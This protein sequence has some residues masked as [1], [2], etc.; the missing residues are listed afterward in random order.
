[1]RKSVLLVAV[2]FV[3][4]LVLANA[5]SLHADNRAA[6]ALA[7]RPITATG[8]AEIKV[9]PDEV[10]LVL[11][12]ETWDKN[13]Q[14]AKKQ[15]DE[16][17]KK[18]TAL[19]KDFG[20]EP[21]YVQ[22][23]QINIEPRYRN[24]TYTDSDFI[25]YF[26]RKTIVITLKDVSKFED[27]FTG[28]LGAGATHVHGIQFRTTELRKYRDQARALAIQAAREKASALA[29]ELG[30]KIGEPQS[31]QENS[32]GWWSSYSA[33]WG[34]RWGGAMSQ[35]V[36]QNVSGGSSFSEEGT[37]APG[38]ISISARVTVTFDLEEGVK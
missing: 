18:I 28:A 9:A 23:D 31:I 11:G 33:W 7:A 19:T 34:G 4:V 16:R 5:P 30:R 37:F 10:I 21:R 15:N 24:G 3:G 29:G 20:I 14:I 32:A 6:P 22:T 1:M 36:V 27:V 26:I 8:E 35:N 12:V 25:G 17:V 38:Q 2:L 13:I